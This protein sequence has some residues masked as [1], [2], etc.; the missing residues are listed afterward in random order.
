MALDVGTRFVLMTT[1]VTILA[2]D[3]AAL[4]ADQAVGLAA[5]RAVGP[6]ADQAVGPEAPA[7]DQAVGPE[8]PAVDRAVGPEAPAADP[9]QVAADQAVG[10]EALAADQAVA[11]VETTTTLDLIPQMAAKGSEV[12]NRQ[13]GGKCHQL[14]PRKFC[15][16]CHDKVMIV[17]LCLALTCASLTRR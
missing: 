17:S 3:Q 14:W 1:M 9:D 15:V 12:E 5:D 10:P 11:L 16:V 7:V 6:A 4:A 8:A 2:M 13:E